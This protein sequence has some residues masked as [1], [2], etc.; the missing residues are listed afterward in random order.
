MK[1]AKAAGLPIVFFNRE[2]EEAVMQAY[3]K[4]WYVGARAEES[5]Y[6]SGALLADYFKANPG[7]DKNGDGKVQYVMLMGEP[8]H[9]EAE[10]RTQYAQKALADAGLIVGF[11][12][13]DYKKLNT[14]LLALDTA[15]WDKVKGNDLMRTFI[16]S[17]GLDK[18]EAVFANNDDMALGVVEML[19]AEGYNSGDPNKY[20]PVV[21]ID[22][23]APAL[24][25]IKEG[26]LLGT[27]LN[28]AINQGKTVVTIANATAKGLTINKSTIGYDITGGKYVW[29]PYVKV[30]AANYREFM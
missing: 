22:A 13:N 25:A 28:D 5:G 14:C 19:K 23:T 24:E 21:G 26:S 12:D 29:I 10:L 27:V 2:P 8:G 3:N 30:T 6:M 4:V 9:Q 16:A 15:M 1:K 17:I 11:D 20:I 18:I 7:A